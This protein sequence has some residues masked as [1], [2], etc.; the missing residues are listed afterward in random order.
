MFVFVSKSVVRNPHRSVFTYEKN[1][2][3]YFVICI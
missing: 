2:L 3:Y 1:T